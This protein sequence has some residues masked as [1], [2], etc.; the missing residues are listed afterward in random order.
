ME[1]ALK[2]VMGK[3]EGKAGAIDAETGVIIDMLFKY[4]IVNES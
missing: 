3:N 4:Y 1:A 2:T